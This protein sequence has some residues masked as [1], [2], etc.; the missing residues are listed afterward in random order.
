MTFRGVKSSSRRYFSRGPG[1]ARRPELCHTQWIA[2]TVQSQTK[3]LEHGRSPLCPVPRGTTRDTHIQEAVSKNTTVACFCCGT[4]RYAVGCSDRAITNEN[5][6]RFIMNPRTHALLQQPETLTYKR[7]FRQTPLLHVFAA[8]AW[9]Q[10]S[11]G[12]VENKSIAVR[13]GNAPGAM[14]ERRQETR[15]DMTSNVKRCN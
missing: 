9:G 8:S 13:L 4:M 10:R 2:A 5:A 7:Q 12:P 3:M 11:A 1:R 15:A 6:W 14:C